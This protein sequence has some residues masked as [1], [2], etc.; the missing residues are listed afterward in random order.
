LLLAHEQHRQGELY[1]GVVGI[2][3]GHLA[4]GLD[5]GWLVGELFVK[6]GQTQPKRGV[7]RPERGG[8]FYLGGG[9]ALPAGLQ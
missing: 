3:A 2:E 4:V 5:L 9:L 1:V 7:V 6:A 8:L